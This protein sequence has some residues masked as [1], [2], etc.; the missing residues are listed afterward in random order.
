MLSQKTRWLILIMP[1]SLC[2]NL[3][4]LLQNMQACWS[5]TH[6][7]YSSNFFF[8]TLSY[9]LQINILLNFSAGED[10]PC[11]EEIQ[12]E[13]NSFHE[14]LRLHCGKAQQFFHYYF[15]P[16]SL[17]QLYFRETL[18]LLLTLFI[19]EFE[20]LLVFMRFPLQESPLRRMRKIR[21]LR[22]K[23]AFLLCS[24]KSKAHLRKQKRSQ[25]RNKLPPVSNK[26][27]HGFINMD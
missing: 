10:C 8:S 16:Y 21:T 2:A 9:L 11:P 25:R 23:A 6:P 12:E 14:E 5:V 19:L 18:L 7:L 24:T 3:I 4:R 17:K 20:L 26:E 27:L 15:W 1:S 13:L 22:L